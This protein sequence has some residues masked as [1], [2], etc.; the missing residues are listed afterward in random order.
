M[1]NRNWED[2]QDSFDAVDKLEDL[3]SLIEFVS[4]LMAHGGPPLPDDYH[5]TH[6][7]YHG[8]FLFFALLQDQMEKCQEAI[9][10]EGER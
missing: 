2:P 3:S 5:F 8:L 1:S 4:D 7:A 10:K 6:S 9:Q